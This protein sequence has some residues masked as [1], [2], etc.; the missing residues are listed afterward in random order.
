MDEEVDLSKDY[1]LKSNKYKKVVVKGLINILKFY[2]FI[3]IEN[4]FIE[5][6]V[7]FDFELLGKVF[8]NLLVSYNF[9]IKIIV[10]K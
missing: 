4:M 5:E 9:E 8:E 7:V 2:K 10:C 1:G 3:V 6:D